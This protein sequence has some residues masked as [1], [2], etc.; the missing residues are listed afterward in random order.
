MA[1]ST[2]PEP[3]LVLVGLLLKLMQVTHQ[4]RDLLLADALWLAGVGGSPAEADVGHS[5]SPDTGQSA[6]WAQV[7]HQVS[8]PTL[9]HWMQTYYQALCLLLLL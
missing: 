1:Q 5:S 3:P 8:W 7:K 4:V 9:A 6:Y 2:P